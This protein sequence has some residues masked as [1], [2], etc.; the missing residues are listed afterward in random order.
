MARI[1]THMFARNLCGTSRDEVLGSGFLSQFA[2]NSLVEGFL[3]LV[4]NLG[5]G[6]ASGNCR[7]GENSRKCARPLGH[8]RLESGFASRFSQQVWRVRRSN[9]ECSN[10][11]RVVTNFGQSLRS[12]SSIGGEQELDERTVEEAPRKPLS[13]RRRTG[14]SVKQLK[15]RGFDDIIEKEKKLKVVLSIKDLLG[16]E[17][18]RSMTLLDLGKVKEDIGFTGNGRLVAFLKRYPAVF[19]VHE[20]AAFGKLPWF[21]FT[22]EAE[23]ALDEELEIRKGM[24]NEVVTKLRKLLMMSRDGTLALAKIAHLGRDL[25]LPDDFRKSLV[26]E[27]PMYFRVLGSRDPLDVEGPKLE[28]VRWS[29]RLAVTE[30]EKKAQGQ[31][32]FGHESLSMSDSG[33]PKRYRLSKFDEIDCP[34]P[35]QDGNNL[36]HRSVQFEKRAVLVIEEL[37]SLTLEKRVL[38]DHLTHFRK[39]FNFSKKVYAML[40]RH[41]EY[42]Y[43]SRKGSRDTV[44][45]R[46]AFEEIRAPGNRKE[47]SLIDKHPLVLV[48]EKFAALMEV[49]PMGHNTDR[50]QAPFQERDLPEHGLMVPAQGPATTKIPW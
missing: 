2:L 21:Q 7:G 16:A 43:V 30:V 20:T 13:S 33:V 39:E 34:S 47:Y 3:G 35:Y 23:A 11:G 22:T 31:K 24:D 6:F 44:F 50:G 9:L 40:L 27:Y 28:L 45:L 38:V 36:H 41:P 14:A 25:G 12:Y 29:T 48:K 37:L 4:G 32:E 15:E 46:G 19:R 26:F 1:L 49:I 17:P 10:S 8:D 18:S 5:L 42:F